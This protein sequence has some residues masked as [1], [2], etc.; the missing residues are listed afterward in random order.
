MY[1]F[2]QS[3]DYDPGTWKGLKAEIGR[4]ASLV[5]PECEKLAV[6]TGHN[7]K[8]DGTVTPSVVYPTEGCNFHEYVT[9]NN[10]N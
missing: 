9:L 2:A 6:L 10:W 3:N 7:I 8:S 4:S 5:C 1:A